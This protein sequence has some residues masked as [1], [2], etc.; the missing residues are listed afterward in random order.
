M[1]PNWK[2]TAA[3]EMDR[4][5]RTLAAAQFLLKGEF[6]EDAT[7]RAYYAVLHAA[8]AAL[9]LHQCA[10]KTH[11]GTQRMF[12]KIMVKSGLIEPEYSGIFSEEHDNREFCDYTAHFEMAELDADQVVADAMKFVNRIERYL[13]EQ[14]TT[15][16]G[17]G[18]GEVVR[19]GRAPAYGTKRACPA[20]RLGRRRKHG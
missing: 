18:T 11:Q 14:T 5:R 20:K 1:T 16:D 12:A 19:E 3:R 15:T 9:G 13:A 2:K 17:P 6:L 7:S 8:K 10:P 4:A